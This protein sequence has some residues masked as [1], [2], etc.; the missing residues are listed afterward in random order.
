MAAFEGMGVNKI[1][2]LT[3]IGYNDNPNVDNDI[4]LAKMYQGLMSSLVAM[5]IQN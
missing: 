1:I 3:H 2:A 5:T 4:L